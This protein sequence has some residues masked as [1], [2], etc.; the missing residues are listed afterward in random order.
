M[1]PVPGP[2]ANEDQIAYW[3]GEAAV[4][5]AAL[6]ERLDAQIAPLGEK[7]MAALAPK[8][9]E[10]VLD[11]G[12]GC[13]ATSLELAARLGPTGAVQAVD[14]SGPMLAVARARPRGSDLAPIEFVQGDAQVFHFKEGAAD[15]AFSRFG[16]MFYADPVA[17]FANVRRGLKRGGR[18]AFVCWRDVALNPFMTLPY[19]A[20]LPLLPP[21]PPPEDPFAP[22]PFA[23]ADGERLRGILVSA[24]YG[25]IVV[26][27]FDCAIGGSDL[28]THAE[29]AVQ[30]GPLGRFLRE[31]PELV[32]PV[33][34][35]VLEALKPHAGTD[36]VKLASATWIVAA[37][38]T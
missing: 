24:G 15:G 9:G 32:A 22:G 3:N 38:N 7:A 29:T 16:V 25:D 8:T 12:C 11:L 10:A 33:R 26:E 36:G 2:T 18:L 19:Q 6:Q 31:C 5:W 34:A 1:K 27:P 35:K 21:Q 13:G 14:I 28:A 4:T 20:A 23:F 30:I 37:Y 17:A